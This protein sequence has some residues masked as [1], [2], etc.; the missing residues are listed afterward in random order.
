MNR[1]LYDSPDDYP[2]KPKRESVTMNEESGFGPSNHPEPEGDSKVHLPKPIK[3]WF[4]KN[5]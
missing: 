4:R 5:G 2:K 3:K 1:E